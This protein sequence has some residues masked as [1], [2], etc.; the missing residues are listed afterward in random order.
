MSNPPSA[1]LA[2]KPVINLSHKKRIEYE[3][4]LS[5]AKKHKKK[6]EF[7]EQQLGKHLKDKKEESIN[8]GHSLMPEV[9][10]RL[11]NLSSSFRL[12]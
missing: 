12:E 11:K 6:G 7:Y 2:L 3:N 10:R 5:W 1:Q 9:Q 8:Q 4:C